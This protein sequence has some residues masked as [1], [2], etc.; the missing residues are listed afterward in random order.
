[1]LSRCTIITKKKLNSNVCNSDYNHFNKKMDRWKD[2]K[3]LLNLF[4]M[5]KFVIVKYEIRI[6]IKDIMYIS[7]ENSNIRGS[8]QN[9]LIKQGQIMRH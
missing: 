6:I 1:M 4:K 2:D 7:Y 8:D 3:S 9:H 5:Q